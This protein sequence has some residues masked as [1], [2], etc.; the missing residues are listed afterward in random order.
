MRVTMSLAGFE[1][2]KGSTEIVVSIDVSSAPGL[3]VAGWNWEP[4]TNPAFCLGD[5]NKLNWAIAAV[6]TAC[7]NSIGCKYPVYPI[8]ADC[9]KFLLPL[10]PTMFPIKF[11]IRG[12]ALTPMSSTKSNIFCHLC[13]TRIAQSASS[14]LVRKLLFT[15][16]NFNAA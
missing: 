4:W 13:S 3:S 1:P 5:V 6:V 14:L 8:N 16:C 15:F 2:E 11:I 10:P 12:L 9:D 7:P